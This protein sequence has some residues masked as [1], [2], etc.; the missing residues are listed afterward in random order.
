M[1]GAGLSVFWRSFFLETLWNYERM[2]N[3]GFSFCIYP[4]LLRLYPDDQVREQAVRRHLEEVN[5]HP[6]MAPLL[7]GITARLEEDLDPTEVIP[8]RRRVM[9]ALAAFGDRLFWNHLKPLAAVVG[10]FLSLY[11]FGSVIGGLVFLIVYNVPHLALRERGFVVGWKA[12]PEALGLLTSSGPAALIAGSRRV[13]SFVLGM[14]AGLLI[15]KTIQS[16]GSSEVSVAMHGWVFPPVLA[17][18]GFWLLRRGVSLI[19][20]IYLTALGAVAFFLLI[21]PGS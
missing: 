21:D 15:I 17:A 10:T 4:V 20:L 18:A 14:T 16:S 8:Y 12:G 11:F 3:V 1:K 13:L 2:Q 5:T 19:P 6:A 9:S 7:V